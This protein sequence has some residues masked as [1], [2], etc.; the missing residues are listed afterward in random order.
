MLRFLL[1]IRL[2]ISFIELFP[3]PALS[4]VTILWVG[5]NALAGRIPASYWEQ[6][7]TPMI[8]FKKIDEERIQNG[9]PPIR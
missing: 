2:I 1:I 5:H 9:L 7:K 3:L 8:H 6:D 4:L